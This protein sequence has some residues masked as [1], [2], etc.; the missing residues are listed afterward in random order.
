MDRVVPWHALS[1][2]EVLAQ[3]RTSVSGLTD[4]DATARL[5]SVGENTIPRVAPASLWHIFVDQCRSLVVGLLVTA[6]LVALITG[7]RADAV[8]IGAVLV[9]NIGVG[10]VIELRARRAV[11]GLARLESRT[12]TVLR[13]GVLEETDARR[14]VPGDVLVLE[15]GQSIAAD[16][17]L[18]TGELRVTEATLTGESVPVSKRAHVV[19]PADAPLPDRS[20]IVHAGTSVVDGA[21]RAVVV[22]TAGATELGTIGRLVASTE[23]EKTPL[24]RQL[25]ELGRQ[26]VWVALLVAVITALLAWA[27]DE[28]VAY[29]VQAALALAVAAVPEGLPAVA[30]IALALAV[31]RMAR[32]HALVRRLPAAESLGSVTVICTDKT[33]TLTAGTMAV[34]QVRTPDVG[35]EVTGTSYAPDGAFHQG[36]VTIDPRRHHDLRRALRIATIASRGDALLTDAGWVPRGDPTESALVVAARKA[37]IEREGAAEEIGEVPFS[38]ER[39][40]MAIFRRSLDGTGVEAYVKGAPARVLELCA[41]VHDREG[42]RPLDAETR[43]RIASWNASMAGSG[44]RV[45]AVASGVVAHAEESAL[46]RLAFAGLIGIADPPAAGVKETIARFRAAG[47]R[48]VMITGDQR[49]TAEAIASDLGLGGTGVTVDGRRLQ[50]LTDAD[51]LELQHTA[52]VFTRVSPA[53]KLRLVTAYQRAGEVVAMIGD[54]VNDAAALKKADIGVT[55]GARGSDVAR[56]TAA[57]VLE[58]D[59]FETIGAAIA[60]GRLVFEN[61]RRFVFFLFSCNLAEVFVLLGTA[62]AGLA[63]P[64]EPIQV[65]WLNLVTDTV[66]ALALAFEPGRPDLMTRPPRPPRSAIVSS[67]FMRSIVT[68]AVLLATPVFALIAWCRVTGIDP[69]MAMTMNFM[70]LGLIQLFH[71]GN[72]RDEAPVVRLPRALANPHAIAALVIGIVSLAGT[73]YVPTLAGLL[74]VARLPASAWIAVLVVSLVPAIVGQGVKVRRYGAF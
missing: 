66:P 7:D 45:L 65:L 28:P 1:A 64:L 9:L 27:H 10:F 37:G 68:Y 5:A 54:G 47:I 4:R 35:Y 41:F 15:A 3:L 49:G 38:S 62:A 13:N 19:I 18:I 21:G 58:D 12:A 39:R 40:L 2:A 71:L 17:R 26:L 57:V 11:E 44:L 31:H 53:E 70:A 43:E 6:A 32:Q 55:M 67:T 46:H 24:E 29:V 73:M 22:A 25:D 20:T 14:V 16:G 23:A 63:L 59:R 36:S 52:T 60:E 8:A 61:I 48:T 72:A 74:N 51:L 33:G 30:T 50:T 42:L 56:E 34:R 69:H